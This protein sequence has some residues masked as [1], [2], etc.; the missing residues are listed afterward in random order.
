MYQVWWPLK[1]YCMSEESQNKHQTVWATHT[2]DNRG[3]KSKNRYLT[4]RHIKYFHEGLVGYKWD[5]SEIVS[6]SCN[7]FSS[8]YINFEKFQF[9]VW[10][11]YL[12]SLW[13]NSVE[14]KHHI[15]ACQSY[16]N[17]GNKVLFKNFASDRYH[18][19]WKVDVSNLKGSWRQYVK[20]T[21]NDCVKIREQ[22]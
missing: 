6:S 22:S 3:D 18:C 17:I 9:S 4:L 21:K 11:P 13:R 5:I 7:N 10:Y 1:R 15:N 20:L 8:D 14:K 2:C 19:F 16:H 12:R